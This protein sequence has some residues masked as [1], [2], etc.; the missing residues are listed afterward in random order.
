MLASKYD[1]SYGRYLGML[2][3][4]NDS[5]AICSRPFSDTMTPYVDHDHDTGQVRGLL[6]SNCNTGLGMLQDSIRV[7]IAAAKYL[8]THGKD[9][10]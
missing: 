6:C 7:L 8:E 2:A 10:V 3:D 5:C 9:F 4:Q 1:L